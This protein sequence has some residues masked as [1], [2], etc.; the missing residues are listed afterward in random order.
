MIKYLL[1]T[2][3]FLAS[4]SSF[5]CETRNHIFLIHGISGSVNTFGSMEKYLN[6][7]DVCNVTTS[8]GYETGNSFLS[9]Y[10]FAQHFH[11][12]VM[13]K[14]KA[15]IILNS[16]KISLIMHSQGGVIG[17]IW[18]NSIRQTDHSL[19]LQVDSFITLS[20]PHWGA[21]MANL[22]KSI[23]FSL[24]PGMGNALSPFGRIELNE[25]SYGSGTIREMV[26]SH[27]DVLHSGKIRSLAL[28]GYKKGINLKSE[29]DV[30]V[31]VYSSRA[32]HYKGDVE[33][34]L[35]SGDV[36]TNFIKTKKTPFVLVNATHINMDL[37]G[38]ADIPKKCLTD[39]LC[40]H[41]SIA[42]ITNHLKGRTIAS[43]VTQLKQFRIGLYINNES[44]EKLDDIKI[45]V[46]KSSAV[47]FTGLQGSFNGKAILKD[48]KAFTIE[49][50]TN[51]KGMQKVVLE[52]KIKNKPTR[53]IPVKAEG[54]FSTIINVNL[55]N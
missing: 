44:S 45:D 31:P 55:V 43:D 13:D 8:F 54:G 2:A 4:F 33:V 23:F 47:S 6:K 5:A 29:S 14:V 21:D 9:T 17:N 35:S 42:S 15:G 53:L 39:K 18:L 37:P 28:A 32:D 24:P 52:L 11:Q 27:D 20:T 3:L 26:W 49:G 41:P 50:S 16:D 22:G 30:V 25:M 48:G 36:A 10:D 40:D 46:I 7:I 38:I 1:F 19:F 12:F 51:L 34:V